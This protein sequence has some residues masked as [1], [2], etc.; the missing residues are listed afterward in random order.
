MKGAINEFINRTFYE[1]FY[2]TLYEI[3]RAKAMKTKG[4]MNESPKEST[5]RISKKEK[6]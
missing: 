2:G 1:T 4:W 5:I 6:G 3:M